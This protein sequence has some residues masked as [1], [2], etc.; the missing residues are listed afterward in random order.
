MISED[1][2]E[3]RQLLEELA[4]DTR[5]Q[6]GAESNYLLSQYLYDRGEVSAAQDNIMSFIREGTPICTG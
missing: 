1:Q 3:V 2:S 4:K 5:S 6:Y